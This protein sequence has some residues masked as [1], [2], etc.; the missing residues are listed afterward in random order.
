[1]RRL[2]NKAICVLTILLSIFGVS[3]AQRPTIEL[4]GFVGGSNYSGDM[5]TDEISAILVQTLPAAGLFVKMHHHPAFHYRVQFMATAVKGADS[6]ASKDWQKLRNLSFV[7]N[8][9]ELSAILEIHFLKLNGRSNF[10]FSPYMFGGIGGFY[11]NPR[12]KYQGSWVYL[13]PLGTEGQGLSE[14]PEKDPYSLTNLALPIGG[15]ITYEVNDRISVGLELGWR[16]TFT[17]YID[18]LSGRYADYNTLYEGSGSL[19]ALLAY[20]EHEITGVTEPYPFEEGAIRGNPDVKDYYA[21][22][23]FSISYLMS[24]KNNK[25]YRR[26]NRRRSN[27]TKCP[28]F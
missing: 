27:T 19:A 7:S 22:G 18:D 15:G 10:I 26:P 2:V 4:G 1:M 11:F 8:I 21:S 28:S 6:Y 13:Q 17:D 3:F 14:Y 12:T 25:R 23:T 24:A 5:T 9:F 20:R 16:I